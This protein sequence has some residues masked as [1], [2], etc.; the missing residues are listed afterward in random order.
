MKNLMLKFYSFILLFF[1]FLGI[2]NPCFSYETVII[3]FPDKEGWHLV[4]SKKTDK[5]TIVQ[6]MP[7]GHT[8]DYWTRTVVFHSY[9]DAVEK[10]ISAKQYQQRLLS[11]VAKKNKTFKYKNIRNTRDDAI[12][13]WCVDKTEKMPA[14]CEIL[15]TTQGYETI[16]SMHYINKNINKLSDIEKNWIRIIRKVRHYY[17]YYRMDRLFNREYI[18]EF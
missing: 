15:R 2:K 11:S 1:I 9:P 4:F 16:V 3:D 17:S 10:N 8:R 14:Q 18:F 13:I 6:F 12:T 5:E 7:S